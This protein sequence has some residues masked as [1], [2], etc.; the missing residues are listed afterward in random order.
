MYI[1][2]TKKLR[3]RL[4]RIPG[5]ALIVARRSGVS[6]MTV[7]RVLRGQ[8]SFSTIKVLEASSD[9]VREYQNKLNSITQNNNHEQN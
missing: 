1:T 7:Y 9:L 4:K 6:T 3:R 2:S 8:S 5:Y